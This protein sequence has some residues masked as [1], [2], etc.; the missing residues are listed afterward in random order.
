MNPVKGSNRDCVSF[1]VSVCPLPGPHCRH[2]AGAGRPR[3]PAVLT[4]GP[5]DPLAVVRVG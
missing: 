5:E 1:L 2:A 3:V 4:A